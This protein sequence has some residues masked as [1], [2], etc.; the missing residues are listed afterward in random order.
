MFGPLPRRGLTWLL[1]PSVGRRFAIDLLQRCC[2]CKVSLTSLKS[3]NRD[4]LHFTCGSF[5]TLAF[6]S[7]PESLN[8]TLRTEF[9]LAGSRR[10]LSSHQ[11]RSRSTRKPLNRRYTLRLVVHR[12]RDLP[13]AGRLPRSTFMNIHQAGASHWY[14]MSNDRPAGNKLDKLVTRGGLRCRASWR[15]CRRSILHKRLICEKQVRR[16][17]DSSQ[18]G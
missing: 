9:V 2:L 18:S 11:P 7:S 3:F 1:R 17:C 16:P 10:P 6:H 15:K 13:E 14:L 4:D 12:Q 5:L 8:V